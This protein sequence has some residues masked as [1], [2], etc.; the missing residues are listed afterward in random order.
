MENVERLRHADEG[1]GYVD[2]KDWARS[3]W[4]N[5]YSL[6]FLPWLRIA[7]YVSF[8]VENIRVDSSGGASIGIPAT[9][10]SYMEI[11]RILGVLNQWA[12]LEAA[13]HDKE[14]Q[15]FVVLLGSEM[16][17]AVARWPMEDKPHKVSAL[18]C[19]GCQQLTLTY[20]PPRW[21]GDQI[22]VDCMCG[23][24]LDDESFAWAIDLIEKEERERRESLGRS[25][26]GNRKSA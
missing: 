10:L 4:A 15:F 13:A 21:E 8:E 12:D 23:Y 19:G 17:T 20:R 24:T 14:G 1:V 11:A 25:A 9:K 16:A 5:G 7:G 18:R 26:R 2:A 22:R 6:K 3:Q